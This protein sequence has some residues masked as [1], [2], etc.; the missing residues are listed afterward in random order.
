MG[1]LDKAQR[2]F[3]E[4]LTR[5]GPGQMSYELI[6]LYCDSYAAPPASIT[7]DIDGAGVGWFVD[8]SP[9]DNVEFDTTPAMKVPEITD[10][11][12]A[13]DMRLAAR[14]VNRNIGVRVIEV[15]FSGFDLGDGV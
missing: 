8:S 11:T 4:S 3:P 14:L 1:I 2:P 12:L 15:S 6:D 13:G 10:E 5:S 7:L 9:S